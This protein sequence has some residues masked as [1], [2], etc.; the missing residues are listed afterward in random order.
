M[1]GLVSSVSVVGNKEEKDFN[2]IFLCIKVE[3]SIVTSEKDTFVVLSLYVIPRNIFVL[4]SMVN[5]RL[6]SEFYIVL[7]ERYNY[8]YNN[9]DGI[10]TLPTYHKVK[11]L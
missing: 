10:T 2:G 1:N 6:K 4:Y 3:V 11:S 5:I 8:S 9:I 7:I